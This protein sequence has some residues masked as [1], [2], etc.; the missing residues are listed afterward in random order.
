MH[1]W[2]VS[3]AGKSENRLTGGDYSVVGY[4]LSADGRKIAFHRAPTPLIA[5]MEQS[6]VWV[7]DASGSGA[8][9][10]T[11][12]TIQENGAALS[13]DGSQIL[14]TAGM[15][16]KAETYYNSKLYLASANGGE[17][18]SLMPDVPY[19]IERAQWSKDGKSILL[20]RQHGRA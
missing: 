13:P 4:E 1:L 18:K 17:P 16:Q 6:E 9:Q 8:R 7:M 14:F 10:I 20:R 3:V 11:H 15:N 12:N 2:T 19:D 5:D